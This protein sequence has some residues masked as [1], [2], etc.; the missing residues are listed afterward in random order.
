MK[1]W[2]VLFIIYFVADKIL[3]GAIGFHYDLISEPFD[4]KK[5]VVDVS[6]SCL[7]WVA[8][9]RINRKTGLLDHKDSK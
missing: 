3:K 7:L 4:L 2:I 8:I 6:I 9:V 1:K 5:L